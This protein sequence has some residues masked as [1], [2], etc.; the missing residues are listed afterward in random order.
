[1]LARDRCHL[2][3]G[4]L[5]A[6]LTAGPGLAQTVAPAPTFAPGPAGAP[7]EADARAVSAILFRDVATLETLYRTLHQN[8]ELSFQ[9]KKTAARLAEELRRAGFEV[10]TG[11]GGHGVVALLT[12]GTGPTVMLRTDMDALPITEETG[13]PFAST[14]RA[15]DIFGREVGVMHACGHDVHMTVMVGTARVLSQLRDRWQG[16]LMIIG[17]PAEEKGQGAKAML[18]DGLF[19]RFPRPDYCIAE[20]TIPDLDAGSVGVVEGFAF[21][22][23]DSVDLVIRGVGGHGASPHTTKDPVVIASQVVLALQT[24]VSREMEPATEPAVVTVG[25]IHG[26]TAYNIIPEEVRL[27]ITVRSYSE[28]A[29]H[30]ILT[31]IER[32]A[33][34]IAVAAGVPDDRMPTMALAEHSL[35]SVYNDPTLTRR[36]AEDFRRTLGEGKVVAL[37]PEMIAEDFGSYG[38]VEP[39]I[40]ICLFRLGTRGGAGAT[41]GQAP[42]AALHSSLYVPDAPAAVATGVRAM[43]A[44]VLDLL[45]P[46]R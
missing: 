31:A 6:V 10:T 16:T 18:D 22:N 46:A 27:Q 35:H 37:S 41:S 40:P 26:G 42:H 20:H 38:R 17:Q 15:R 39:R 1:M 21:A 43:S 44:A 8:P 11:V 13:L 19:T 45:R 9:E 5:L 34:G 4:A 3:L 30:K 24:I 33:R 7:H 2:A 12:N 36:L 23:V 28:K 14:V 25:S 29:R 32:T